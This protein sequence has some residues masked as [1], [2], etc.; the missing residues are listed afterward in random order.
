VSKHE[1]F[2]ELEAWDRRWQQRCET[3]AEAAMRAGV[4]AEY[5]DWLRTADG[6]VYLERMR[7]V[8]DTLG[9]VRKEQEM[10]SRARYNLNTIGKV[11]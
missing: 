8:P 5:E 7:N 2:E 4:E 11:K 10:M 1:L 6:I 3:I 9:A